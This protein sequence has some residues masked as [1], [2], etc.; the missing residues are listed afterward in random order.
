MSPLPAPPYPPTN[1]LVAVAWLS[2]RVAGLTAGM[3]ATT[4][5]SDTAA[6][7]DEGFVQ[8]QALPGGVPDVDVPIRRPLFQLDFWAVAPGSGKPPWNKANRLAELVRIAVEEGQQY[9]QPVTL[10]AT[11]AGARVLSVRLESEPLRMPG[12]PSGYARFTADLAIDW[13]RA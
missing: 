8:A 4:L 13:V 12:D 11:Y 6:W 9:G 5:P 2:Q 10:P 7:A 3:V 1:E